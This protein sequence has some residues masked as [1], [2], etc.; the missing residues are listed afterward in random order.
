M[1]GEVG[2][3]YLVGAGPGDP[4]LLTRRGEAVLSRADVVVYDHLANQ[5]LLDLAS[6]AAQR[7]CGGK[8]VG[9]CTLTQDKISH[10]L[11]DHA[12]AG[13][14]VVRLKGG[15]PLVFGR[16]GE[17]AIALRT[18]GIPFEIVPGVTAGLGVL[19]HAGIPVTHRGMSSAVAFVTGHDDPDGCLNGN[20]L[21]WEALARFPGTLVVYMGVTHLE[22][23]C[24]TL[25]K[26]GKP[27]D[28]PAAV[29]EAGTLASQRTQVAKL[30]TIAN[31]AANAGAR[32]PALLVIGAVVA[33]REVMAW[34]EDLP[35][36]GQ[37]IVI[38]RPLEEAS[39]VAAELESLGAEALLAP[40]V[41]LRPITDAG[42]LDEAV[43]RLTD[44][45]WL[46]FTSALAS[47]S[48]FSGSSSKAT[49]CVRSAICGSRRSV[50]PP[51][52]R[53]RNST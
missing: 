27:A 11:I 37:R 17:E 16:G 8:S 21:D 46:V 12:R 53:W 29:I 20:L 51:R 18:A 52:M 38:T 34:Y 2:K 43:S 31:V 24:R 36:F 35:L 33:L 26:L 50:P 14:I 1:A 42:P 15:D 5:R 48:S 47:G 28:T 44:Y 49:T 13:R 19:G 6:P 22:S 25:I 32:P 23:I 39:R 3:V 10:I 40:A 7:I 30:E 41:T 9:H 4:G 45:D